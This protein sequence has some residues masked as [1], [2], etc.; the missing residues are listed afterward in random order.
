MVQLCLEITL[1]N[2]SMDVKISALFTQRCPLRSA[3]VRHTNISGWNK[4]SR[5]A[6]PQRGLYALS[7]WWLYAGVPRSHL[8]FCCLR[9]CPERAWRGSL[10]HCQPPYCSVDPLLSDSER[11][12]VSLTGNNGAWLGAVWA[13]CQREGSC[14]AGSDPPGHWAEPKSPVCGLMVCLSNWLLGFKEEK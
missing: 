4:V 7:S 3:G 6:E 2:T 5:K 1:E 10:T 12:P 14:P 9:E 8:A 11:L 13:F